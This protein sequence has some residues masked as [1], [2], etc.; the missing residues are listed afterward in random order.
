MRNFYSVFCY[1][2]TVIKFNLLLFLWTFDFR[3]VLGSN[4][5]LRLKNY[6][7]FHNNQDEFKTRRVENR[8]H[9][10]LTPGDL[11]KKH[12]KLILN[13]IVQCNYN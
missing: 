9:P 4:L 1:F 5:G 8:S 10:T 6:D 13:V 7:T 3:Y 11:E 2:S 12:F